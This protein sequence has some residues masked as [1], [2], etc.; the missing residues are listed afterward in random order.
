MTAF[1]RK[2]PVLVTKDMVEGMAP[3]SVIVDMAAETGGNCELT[4]KDEK[5]VTEN[6]VTIGSTVDDLADAYGSSVRFSYEVCAS[7]VAGFEIVGADS[8]AGRGL[9]GELSGLPDSPGT[10]VISVGAGSFLGHC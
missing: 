9:W 7:N 4:V 2:P 10:V 3:G 8:G 6:G 5:I 1:G